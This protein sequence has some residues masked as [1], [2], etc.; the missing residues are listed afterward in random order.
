LKAAGQIL[1]IA[2]AL[3][4]QVHPDKELAGK[5]RKKN[6]RKFGDTNRKYSLIP[7]KS[8]P[9]TLSTQSTPYTPKAL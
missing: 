1:S 5:L 6:R 9:Y 3:P 2:K 4:L 7:E 8:S